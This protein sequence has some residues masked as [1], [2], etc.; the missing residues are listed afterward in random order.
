MKKAKE[1]R[2][3]AEPVLATVLERN[4]HTLLAHRKEQEKAKNLEDQFAGAVTGITGSMKFVYTHVAVFGLWIIWNLGLL[5][6]PRF[7]PT[8]NIL[9]MC[10]SVEAIFLSTFVLISQNRMA[11]LADKRA[12]LNLQISLL[13]EH[14][15]T[16]VIKMVQAIA[17]HLHLE[18]SRDPE[19]EELSQDVRPERILDTL[20]ETEQMHK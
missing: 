5:Q 16:R 17:E 1:E 19:L 10:A 3:G 2:T 15:V 14:E 4:I 8:F 12:D 13:A 9:A 7:D 18:I 20:E 6:L 11:E